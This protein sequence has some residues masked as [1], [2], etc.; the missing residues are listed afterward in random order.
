MEHIACRSAR[1]SSV[2]DEY[3]ARV[4]SSRRYASQETS[5]PPTAPTRDNTPP[6][7][8][9]VRYDWNDLL[10]TVSRTPSSVSDP[11]APAATPC[12][13]NVV[14]APNERTYSACSGREPMP[15][16]LRPSCL[17]DSNSGRTDA[18]S[19]PGHG[20]A[21]VLETAH[22]SQAFEGRH[23]RETRRRH[24]KRTDVSCNRCN[25]RLVND[26]I[27]GVPARSAGADPAECLHHGDDALSDAKV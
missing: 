8:S 14:A 15:I 21:A 17:R 16:T 3:P 1:P 4:T 10:A 12:A 26:N 22:F 18:A 6:L 9:A 23:A 19:G 24:S 20:D 25:S 7:R 5:L 2:P 13:D 11:S 27:F